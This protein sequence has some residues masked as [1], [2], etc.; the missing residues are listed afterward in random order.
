MKNKKGGAVFNFLKFI[1]WC[2]IFVSIA[3]IIWR[4]KSWGE[5]FGFIALDFIVLIFIERLLKKPNW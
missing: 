3:I 4:A 1:F 5:K 2:I